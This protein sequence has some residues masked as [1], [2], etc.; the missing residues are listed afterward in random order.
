[1]EPKALVTCNN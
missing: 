1:M